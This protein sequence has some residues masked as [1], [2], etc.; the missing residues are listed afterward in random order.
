[1]TVY[2]YPGGMVIQSGTIMEKKTFSHYFIPTTANNNKK[3]NPIFALNCH[4]QIEKILVLDLAFLIVMNISVLLF[5]HKIFFEK[6]Y[7]AKKNQ[8]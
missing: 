7:N 1:M 8:Q 2:K 6:E 3:T 4:W 5:Y